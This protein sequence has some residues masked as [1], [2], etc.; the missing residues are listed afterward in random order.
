M[1][2]TQTLAKELGPYNVTVNAI[3]PGPI[4]T[5]LVGDIYKKSAKTLGMSYEEYHKKVISSIPLGRLGSADEVASLVAFIASDMANYITGS[6]IET[7]AV[8]LNSCMISFT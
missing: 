6:I 8:R 1:D 2:I 3:C 4:E 7:P 5:E